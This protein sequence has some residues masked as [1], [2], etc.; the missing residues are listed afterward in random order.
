M[1]VTMQPQPADN[2]PQQTE[3]IVKPKR[4]VPIRDNLRRNIEIPATITDEAERKR[5]YAREYRKIR[6]P[7]PE[8]HQKQ[9]QY[10]KD[11]YN[12]AKEQAKRAAGLIE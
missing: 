9:L 5:Y 11:S 1:V 3:V 2:P 7:D 10:R 12:R 8:Y 6:R 4:K